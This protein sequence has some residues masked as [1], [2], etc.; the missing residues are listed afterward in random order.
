MNCEDSYLAEGFF[1]SLC[2]C[3]DIEF[4]QLGVITR[5]KNKCVE[6][7]ATSDRDLTINSRIKEAAVPN[8]R[9]YLPVKLAMEERQ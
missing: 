2:P 1:H 8:W 3:F 6:I 4:A 7:V 5:I 9:Y